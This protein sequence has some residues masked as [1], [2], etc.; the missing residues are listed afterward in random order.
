MKVRGLAEAGDEL[1][2]AVF[3]QQAMALGRLFTIAANFTDP[4]A[5]FLGGGVVESQPRFRSGSSTGSACTCSCGTSRRRWRRWS[6][7]RT[8]T[9]PARAAPR[10]PPATRVARRQAV[11]VHRRGQAAVMPAALTLG[12]QVSWPRAEPE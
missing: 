10:S 7:C 9:W 6:W 2:L 11:A 5:Y 4:H 12:Y 3:E 1:A 8:G